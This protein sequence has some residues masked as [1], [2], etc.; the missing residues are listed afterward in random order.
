MWSEITPYELKE[1]LEHSPEE[2]LVLDVREPYEYEYGRLPSSLHIPMGE[3]S[4]RT[5]EIPR[6]GKVVVCCRS[7][8]RSLQIIRYLTAEHNFSNL[9]NLRGGLLAWNL[10]VDQDFPVY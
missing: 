10:E 3:I 6:N 7:G 5:N 9:L 4:E 1:L 2:V 8:S